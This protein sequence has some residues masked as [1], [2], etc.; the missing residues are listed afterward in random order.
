MSKKKEIEIGLA[1]AHERGQV[2]GESSGREGVGHIIITAAGFTGRMTPREKAV[3]NTSFIH[4]AACH[5]LGLNSNI[6]EHGLTGD[7][8][9][10]YVLKTGEITSLLT[11]PNTIKEV[12]GNVQ[13]LKPDRK[14][15]G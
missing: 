5:E 9:T 14:F 10:E 8:K 3:M 13:M 6:D 12:L 15:T 1:K 2:I 7:H 11:D 4:A